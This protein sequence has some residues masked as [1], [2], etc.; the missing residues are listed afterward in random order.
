M[1]SRGKESY[2]VIYSI[3]G[4]GG[5]FKYCAILQKLVSWGIW[6]SILTS[7]L[8]LQS[9]GGKSIPIFRVKK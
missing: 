9:A 6:N 8:W 5:G 4:G 3:G 1:L 7:I 2:A